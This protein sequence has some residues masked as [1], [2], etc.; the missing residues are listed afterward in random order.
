MKRLFVDPAARAKGVGKSIVRAIEHAA[1][2]EGVRMLLLETG[3]KSFEALRLYGRVGF[4]E[5]GPFAAY[6]PDPLS[7]FMIK[8]L[9]TAE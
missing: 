7:V 9:P 4:V 5:C 2:A 6:Q 3:I 1:T 8:R